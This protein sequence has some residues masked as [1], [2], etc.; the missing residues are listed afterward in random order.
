[1]FMWAVSITQNSS[2]DKLRGE[3]LRE[4]VGTL[5]GDG[6]SVL[7]VTTLGGNGTLGCLVCEL[8]SVISFIVIWAW[9]SLIFDLMIR[10]GMGGE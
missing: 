1:M 7:G 6:W 8:L 9:E 10:Q 5:R 4:R 2:W 3:S